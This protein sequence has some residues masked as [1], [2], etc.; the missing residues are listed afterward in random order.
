MKTYITDML[1]NNY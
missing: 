1:R